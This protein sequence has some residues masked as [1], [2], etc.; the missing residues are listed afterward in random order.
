MIVGGVTLVGLFN[1]VLSIYSARDVKIRKTLDN[2]SLQPTR[3][4]KETQTE[5]SY[6]VPNKD[7]KDR[8]FDLAFTISNTRNVAA[9]RNSIAHFPVRAEVSPIIDDNSIV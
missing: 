2:I 7:E 5:D 9:K 8:A 1:L 3:E 6:F 4:D